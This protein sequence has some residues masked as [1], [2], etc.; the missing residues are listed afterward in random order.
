MAALLVPGATAANGRVKRTGP[1]SPPGLA[2][3]GHITSSPAEKGKAA[4]SGYIYALAERTDTKH[5]T[6]GFFCRK[7]SAL[8]TQNIQYFAAF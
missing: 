5:Y 7:S 1:A 8:F 2:H 6:S 3:C 4:A